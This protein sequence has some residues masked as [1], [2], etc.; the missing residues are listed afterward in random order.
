MQRFI[1]VRC[2][3][4]VLT[5]F[6][7]A[8][9]VFLLGRV[10]G[11]P[12]DVLL[13]IEATQEDYERVR[14]HWGL[15]RPLWIQFLVFLRNV[16]RGNFGESLSFPGMSAME[17]VLGRLPATIELAVLAIGIATVIAVPIGVI[18]AVRRDSLVDHLGKFVALLGQSL[19]SFWLAIM[20]IWVFSVHLGWL[21]TS[22]RGDLRHMILPA[23]AMGWFQVAAVMRLTRSAML[24]AL[25]TEYVKLARIKGLPEWK[26]VWKHALR[27]AA[28]VPLTYYGV[29]VGA[30]LTGSVVAETVFAWPGIGRLAVDAVRARDYT[31]VQ[32]VVIV[33][34]T[35][36][37][38]SNLLVDL[39]YAYLDP[40]I[41]YDRT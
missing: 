26:I 28:I 24:E 5:L 14:T 27:N 23:I 1:L 21:P 7:A 2:L 4:S 29:I 15:D 3:Q 13:P 37:I 40:R 41:R 9:V 39:L 31:V 35:I 33:F 25:D 8:L 22:G 11:D 36:F 12:L 6:V 16:V 34:V 18:A 30:L 17:V 10:T 38:L 19:P 20:L 32:T